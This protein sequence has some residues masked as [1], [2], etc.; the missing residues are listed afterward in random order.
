[1]IDTEWKIPRDRYRLEDEEGE[2][3]MERYIMGDI[4]RKRYTV[5]EM[6]KKL[7][8]LVEYK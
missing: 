6:Q 1:M 5:E 2:I 3:E 4:Q 8:R 7:R